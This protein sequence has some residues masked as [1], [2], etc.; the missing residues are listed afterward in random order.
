MQAAT[1]NKVI[2]PTTA[3]REDAQ[4]LERVPL[5]LEVIECKQKAA[6]T[7]SDPM[8]VST[9]IV[10]CGLTLG[11]IRVHC[12]GDTLRSYYIECADMLEPLTSSVAETGEHC[13]R[14]LIHNSKDA[15]RSFIIHWL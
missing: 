3:R 13:A 10:I 12:D 4:K 15:T 6:A 7:E 9:L 8:H 5:E 2:K 14:L 1:A 11:S